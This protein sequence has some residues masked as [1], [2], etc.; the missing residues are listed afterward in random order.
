MLCDLFL[1]NISCRFLSRN[2]LNYP[3]DILSF[4]N[5][6]FFCNSC[7]LVLPHPMLH[8]TSRNPAK[9]F[10]STSF[11][12]GFEPSLTPWCTHPDKWSRS[13]VLGNPYCSEAHL[14]LMRSCFTSSIATTMDALFHFNLSKSDCRQGKAGVAWNFRL[15]GFFCDQPRATHQNYSIDFVKSHSYTLWKNYKTLDFILISRHIEMLIY[16]HFATFT[17]TNKQ[18]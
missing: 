5:T 4:C 11:K 9:S 18:S 3:S 17:W 14:T 6:P 12:Y 16:F 7:F 8:V 13:V 15:L 2:G 1:C 10:S